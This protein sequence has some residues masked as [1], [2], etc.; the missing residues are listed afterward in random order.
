[1]AYVTVPRLIVNIFVVSG[2]RSRS[3]RVTIH[4]IFKTLFLLCN[5]YLWQ[6]PY[7]LD[8][9]RTPPHVH[10]WIKWNCDKFV[11]ETDGVKG[12]WTTKHK[13]KSKFEQW[14][15]ALSMAKWTQFM[16]NDCSLLINRP[17][18]ANYKGWEWSFKNHGSGKIY[19]EF[20]GFHRILS[21]FIQN[22]ATLSS[23]S[24]LNLNLKLLER[25]KLHGKEHVSNF[26]ITLPW[27]NDFGLPT[28]LIKY[29]KSFHSVLVYL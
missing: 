14:S 26:T 7:F 22:L 19:N 25:R 29:I 15:M 24:E 4:L 11:F 13:L 5:H 6:S 21:K 16:A 10:Y 23:K 27:G 12:P 2:S 18:W 1:M 28:K 20:Y 3:H 9:E 17:P 8:F